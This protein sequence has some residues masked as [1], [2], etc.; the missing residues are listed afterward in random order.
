MA[1]G[2]CLLAARWPCADRVLTKD[3][4]RSATALKLSTKSCFKSPNPCQFG[5]AC[6]T[7]SVTVAA[8]AKC[9]DPDT[10]QPCQLEAVCDGVH[11]ECPANEVK[12]DGMS[13][14]NI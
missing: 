3:C 11:A 2:C 7:G 8:G 1:F 10:T 5:G 12:K 14:N 6:C 13:Q 9:R 4:C